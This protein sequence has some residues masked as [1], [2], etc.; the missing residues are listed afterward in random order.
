MFRKETLQFFGP[1]G[2][3]FSEKMGEGAEVK[4]REI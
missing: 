4:I 3:F 1:S 2:L